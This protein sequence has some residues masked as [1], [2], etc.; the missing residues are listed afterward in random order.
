MP[1]RVSAHKTPPRPGTP[2][3]DSPVPRYSRSCRS[4]ISTCMTGLLSQS[5]FQQRQRAGDEVGYAHT[6]CSI[7]MQSR[8]AMAHG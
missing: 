7:V 2:S 6:D 4:S 8:R 1:P 3:P 5:C